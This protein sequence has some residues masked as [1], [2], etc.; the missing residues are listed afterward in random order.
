MISSDLLIK[1]ACQG[2]FTTIGP[3]VKSP[4]GRKI[5]GRW[6]IKEYWP[7]RIKILTW[8]E[9][10]SLQDQVRR[11]GRDPSCRDCAHAPLAQQPRPPRGSASRACIGLLYWS[12]ISQIKLTDFKKGQGSQ[13]DCMLRGICNLISMILFLLKRCLSSGHIIFSLRVVIKTFIDPA[14][15]IK[16]S[17]KVV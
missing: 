11:A 12:Y 4:I 16:V 14:V 9:L 15:L 10:S 2:R 17:F 6:R 7:K 13:F 5:V 3:C 1:H 8:P